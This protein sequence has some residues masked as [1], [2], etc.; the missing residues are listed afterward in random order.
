MLAR[1]LP[2]RIGCLADHTMQVSDTVESREAKQRRLR[3]RA[4][5]SMKKRSRPR[6]PGSRACAPQP[7]TARQERRQ[8]DHN[9]RRKDREV[10][11]KMVLET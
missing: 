7:S 6:P 8:G 11:F 1:A 2:Q 3:R 10:Q 4:S 5:S 9:P